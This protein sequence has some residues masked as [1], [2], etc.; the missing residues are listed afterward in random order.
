MGR[1]MSTTT[2]DKSTN[3]ICL[4]GLRRNLPLYLKN[5]EVNSLPYVDAVKNTQSM[6]VS[7]YQFWPTVFKD[8]SEHDS[9]VDCK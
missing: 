6:L 4:S 3:E 2:I 8:M 7:L 1:S 5:Y 9:I